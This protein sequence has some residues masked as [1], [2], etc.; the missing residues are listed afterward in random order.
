MSGLENVWKFTYTFSNPGPQEEYFS[1][2]AKAIFPDI[3]PA[4]NA[5]SRQK[6][7]ILADPKQISDILKSERQKINK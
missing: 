4:W 5:S 1:E 6:I 2:G 3:F 7:P